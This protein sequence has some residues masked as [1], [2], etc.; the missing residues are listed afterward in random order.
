MKKYDVFFEQINRQCFTV[1]AKDQN[2]AI[3][4][5]EKEW[6]KVNMRPGINFV[7]EHIDDTDE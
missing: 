1:E 6:R 3:R 2:D 7:E 5:A 4:K